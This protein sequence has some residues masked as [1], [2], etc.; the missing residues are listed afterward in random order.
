MHINGNIFWLGA[1]N[2]SDHFPWFLDKPQCFGCFLEFQSL[3]KETF[4]EGSFVYFCKWIHTQ[5]LIFGITTLY[6]LDHIQWQI[7]D[8]P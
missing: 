4:A 5:M 3:Q 1:S 8:F 6:V 7:Q 2:N